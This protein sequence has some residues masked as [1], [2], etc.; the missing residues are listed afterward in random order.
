MPILLPRVPC[1]KEKEIHPP[2]PC[3]DYYEILRPSCSVSI[4]RYGLAASD[5]AFAV[6][7]GS[8]VGVGAGAAAAA[9]GAAPEA[10]QQAAAAL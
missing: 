1:Y 7:F 9:A 5:F 3:S 10:Q 2:K 8:G 6:E 4:S